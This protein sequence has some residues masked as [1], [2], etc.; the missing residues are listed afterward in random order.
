[1][2]VCLIFSL[3]MCGTNSM[4]LHSTSFQLGTHSTTVRFSLTV[5]GTI[6]V[7]LT[8]RATMRLTQTSISF[9]LVTVR[10]LVTMRVSY[11]AS[12]LDGA[13]AATAVVQQGCRSQQL[14]Q[15]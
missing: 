9:S 2:Q 15:P 7:R 5:T 3:T 12:V 13:G 14:L 4:Y 10:Y 1:M 11:L 8:S 6:T